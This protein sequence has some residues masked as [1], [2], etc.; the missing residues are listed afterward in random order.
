MIL[1]TERLVLRPW[2]ETDAES[3]YKYAKD[4]RVGPVAGWP[5]HKSIE[6]SAEII[7]TIF[8]QEGVFA[9]TLKDEDIAVGCIGLHRGPASNFPIGKDEGEIGYWIGVPYWGK[10]LIPEAT[11]EIMRYGFENLKLTTLWC[12]YFAGNEKSKRVQEKCGFRYHHTETDKPWP[13]LN[14]IR[15]EHI[16]RITKKEWKEY[17][18]R[19]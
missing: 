19:R 14:D 8:A 4:E 1:K 10:G 15:T 6:E 11:R 13:L 7:R 16:S 2:K 12:G 5:P 18:A 17:L 3:L 9:V